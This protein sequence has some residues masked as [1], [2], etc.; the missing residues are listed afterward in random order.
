MDGAKCANSRTQ[1]SNVDDLHRQE[2]A[3]KWGSRS[4]TSTSLRTHGTT[5]RW[6]PFVPL[7]LRCAKKLMTWTVFPKPVIGVSRDDMI[8]EARIVPISS[9]NMKLRH[10]LY[11][12]RSQL[13][14]R[15]W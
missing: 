11:K 4:T 9:A 13:T 8:G 1:F 5:M 2:M 10:F 12:R 14:P 6:G 3:R 15:S 7:S